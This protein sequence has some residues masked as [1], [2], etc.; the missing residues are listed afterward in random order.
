[1]ENDA[2][3]VNP[4]APGRPG[5]MRFVPTES[6]GNLLA[7]R[8][9]ALVFLGTVSIELLSSL[10]RL[11]VPEVTLPLVPIAG[12]A[13]A[14]LLVFSERA[15]LPI[16]AGIAVAGLFYAGHYGALIRIPSL[17][18]GIILGWYISRRLFAG[19]RLEAPLLRPNQTLYFII[20][21]GICV[22]TLSATFLQ[23]GSHITSLSGSSADVWSWLRG[24]LA[25]MAGIMAFTPA[26]Y[27]LLRGDFTT[28][29]KTP[30]PRETT[31]L[32]SSLLAS[33]A[34]AIVIPVE[35]HLRA[36]TL[37]TLPF[38]FL[39]WIALRRGLRPISLALTLVA[40]TM[41]IY[42][43]VWNRSVQPGPV[44]SEGLYQLQFVF[45]AITCLMLASQRDAISALTLKTKL[46]HEAAE[47]CAWEWSLLGGITFWSRGWT[48]RTGLLAETAMPLQ[49]WIETVHPDDQQEFAET[50]SR[51]A[52]SPTPGFTMRFRSWDV[53][54]SDWYWTKSIGHIIKLDPD[55]NPLKAIGLVLDINDV[56]EAEK[57]RV[58]A[59][60]NEAE[61]ATLRAQLNPHFLFNCLNSIRA[62]IGLDERKA[63]DMVTTLSAL[64]RGL[65][66]QRNNTFETVAAELD[67]IQKYLGL[68]Q[69]RFGSRLHTEYAIDP[70][71]MHCHIPCFLMLTLVENAVKHGISKAPDGGNL[72]IQV[73][74]VQDALF[75]RV[76]NTGRLEVRPRGKGVGLENTR[77]RVHLMTND[78]EA[79]EIFEQPSGTVV[80]TV[81]LPVHSLP[82]PNYNP[83]SR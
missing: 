38:P 39:M 32:F 77:R 29:V 23:I 40:T 49:R 76:A 54:R 75:I 51:G 45:S 62:L 79:F 66:E 55:G 15:I 6:R 27:Y 71:A 14:A 46:A 67:I 17:S 1:M 25:I 53:Y 8:Q 28:P 9:I 78:P 44:I 42:Y 22:A 37:I 4:K 16:F 13:F 24:F 61:L 65:L 83:M 68:E 52:L 74:I 2:S 26:S 69:I 57:L 11:Q 31:F 81:R 35:S 10:L 18:I 20:G 58:A 36:A 72:E 59:V 41:L 82:V 56:V 43:Y 7:W 60:Q 70:L 30:H 3:A 19:K 50:I 21:G 64:L 47:F 80:A 73:Y 63:R 48:D 34:L 5:L 33:I 12:F